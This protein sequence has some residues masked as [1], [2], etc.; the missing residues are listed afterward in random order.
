MDESELEPLKIVLVGESGV[1]KTSIIQQ[2]VDQMFQSDQQST[3]GGTFRTKTIKCGNGKIIKLE[4]WDTAGQE[5]YRS[6]SQ[7]FY[8]DANAAILV[9]DITNKFSFEEIQNYWLTQVKESATENIIMAIVGNKLDLYEQELV[10]QEE[11]KKY[12]EDN[13]AFFAVTSAKNSS[14]IEDLFIEI[15]KKFS[16]ADSATIIQDINELENLHK[17][18]K[19][20]V[21][22][23]KEQTIKTTKKKKCC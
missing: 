15:V 22:I 7:L 19:E 13:N 16:G 1:G 23:T 20:T 8:K 6:I 4:I 11:A 3:I 10:N 18:R 12:A 14:G 5:R 9:Y 21:K 2:F 17:Y